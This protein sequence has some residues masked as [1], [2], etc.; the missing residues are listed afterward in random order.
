M[1]SVLGLGTA[2]SPSVVAEAEAYKMHHASI[3]WGYRFHASFLFLQQS[4]RTPAGMHQLGV[5]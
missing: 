1:I 3:V 2:P 5:A 4:E